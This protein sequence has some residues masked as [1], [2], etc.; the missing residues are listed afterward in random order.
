MMME[1]PFI[2]CQ[3]KSCNYKGDGPTMQQSFG[4]HSD[5]NDCKDLGQFCCGLS[6]DYKEEVEF[7]GG[8]GGGGNNGPPTINCPS[9]ERIILIQS[10]S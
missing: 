3:T 10:P 8:N 1:G 6:A 2:Y 7:C 5:P 9:N 4:G